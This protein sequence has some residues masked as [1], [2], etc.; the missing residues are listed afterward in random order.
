MRKECKDFI[1]MWERRCYPYGIPDDA[2]QEIFDRV[3]SY[4]MVAKA[5]LKNDLSVLGVIKKPCKAYISLK[6]IEIAKRET[7]K[8]K[9]QLE[10]NL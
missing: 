6:R 8:P 9:I 5:I 2:P 7:T 10:L 4:R 1:E 3:P